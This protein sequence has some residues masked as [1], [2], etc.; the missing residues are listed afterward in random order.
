[1]QLLLPSVAARPSTPVDGCAS[2]HDAADCLTVTT[3]RI[4]RRNT[5]GKLFAAAFA[6]FA[7]APAAVYFL[8][9]NSSGLIAGQVGISGCLAAQ[10]CLRPERLV[11][12]IMHGHVLC[13][14]QVALVA[15]GALGGSAAFAGGQLLS[16]LQ[17]E[18]A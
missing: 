8:P 10:L 2:E 6:L 9:D 13:H 12:C 15:L 18:V 3:R 17:K 5:P 14:V 11:Y 1:V 7:L 4:H 16:T